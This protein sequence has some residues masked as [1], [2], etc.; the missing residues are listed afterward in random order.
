MKNEAS[1]IQKLN[2]TIDRFREQAKEWRECAEQLMLTTL[3]KD[4]QPP[5]WQ[6]AYG[7]YMVL[8]SKYYTPIESP[9]AYLGE[10]ERRYA[11]CENE[12]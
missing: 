5:A 9:Y 1:E 3:N 2:E 8:E 12:D 6:A 7:Q 10:D 11:E 4:D